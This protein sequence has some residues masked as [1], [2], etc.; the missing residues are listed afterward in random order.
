M[1]ER[2]ALVGLEG[3]RYPTMGC[4]R[5]AGHDVTVINRITSKARA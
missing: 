3:M 4:Q 1:T 5:R 2:V